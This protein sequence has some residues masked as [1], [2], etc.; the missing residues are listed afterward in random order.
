MQHEF[1]HF[2]QL[3]LEQLKKEIEA[4]PDENSIWALADGI[5]NSAGTL[6]CHLCGNLNHFIGQGMGNTGYVR[7]RPLEFSIRDVPRA[8][9]IKQIEATAAMLKEVLPGLDLTRVY[10]PEYWG[11][12]MTVSNSLLRLLGHLNYHLGQVN[13]H[14]R[15]LTHP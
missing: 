3:H 12:T 9:L 1:L 5:H 7:D 4:Y 13:Y 11:E 6:C 2:F 10:L 8:D 14:R 15:L